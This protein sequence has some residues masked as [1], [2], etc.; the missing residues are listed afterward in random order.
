MCWPMQQSCPTVSTA[1]RVHAGQ[2]GWMKAEGRGETRQREKKKAEI[3]R[4]VG[5]PYQSTDISKIIS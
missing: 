4:A 5:V 2:S 3:S 1:H